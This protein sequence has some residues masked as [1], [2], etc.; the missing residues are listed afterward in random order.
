MAVEAADMAD[1]APLLLRDR[2]LAAQRQVD[3]I[4]DLLCIFE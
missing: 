3:L 4:D 2:L 1:V